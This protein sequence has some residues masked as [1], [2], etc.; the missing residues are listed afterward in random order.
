M[1]S[2]DYSIIIPHKNIPELLQRC[3]DSIPRRDDLEI[4]VVD[5]NSSPE[6]VDFD[7]FPGMDRSDVVMVR[8]NESK[9]A[10]GARNTGV[11]IARGRWIL[12]VD[13][14]DMF[15]DCI[16]QILDDYKS[17]TDFDVVYFD[18][19]YLTSINPYIEKKGKSGILQT[20]ELYEKEPET[21]EL[22]FRFKFLYPVGKLINR[23]LFSNGEVFFEDSI[24]MNDAAFSYRLGYYAGKVSVDAR[25]IQS[26]IIRNNSVSRNQSVESY[27]E[28]IRIKTE[29]ECFYRDH[30][31][32]LSYLGYN[33][34]LFFFKMILKYPSSFL[35]G[36]DVIHRA[37]K[38]YGQI[39]AELPY[40]GCWLLWRKIVK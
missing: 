17:K 14:D 10:G 12:F 1:N 34:Y 13:A 5:N 40:A 8:D 15:N 16:N 38:G 39:I 28:R 7:H 36:I 30:S 2:I 21:A 6:L 27:L 20:I 18:L 24:I 29:A 11:S 3:L 19:S 37:G 22:L 9:G 31:I 32:P 23:Q 25:K 26:I 4:I 33:N 35:K